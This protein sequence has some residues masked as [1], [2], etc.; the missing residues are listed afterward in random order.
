VDL[1][2]FH[3]LLQGARQFIH[4]LQTAGFQLRTLRVNVNPL[5]N[6]KDFD[7]LGQDI[8]RFEVVKHEGDFT[9][10]DYADYGQFG[11]MLTI[12]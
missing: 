4:E 12:E 7:W 1:F 3:T 5:T 6:V 10:F 11:K 8:P 2:T 9:W